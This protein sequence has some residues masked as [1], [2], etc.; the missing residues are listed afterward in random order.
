M[1]QVVGL[2]QILTQKTQKIIEIICDIQKKMIWFSSGLETVN[3]LLNIFFLNPKHRQ[4]KQI[5][6]DEFYKL[7]CYN[8]KPFIT[9]PPLP[10][11]WL[12]L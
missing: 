12:Y 2:T 8:I 5:E 6:R 1:P 10:P 7:S 3:S 9:D 4:L 11:G